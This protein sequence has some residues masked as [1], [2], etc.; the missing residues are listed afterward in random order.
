MWCGEKRKFWLQTRPKVWNMNTNLVWALMWVI[1][2]PAH[3]ISKPFSYSS[4]SYYSYFCKLQISVVLKLTIQTRLKIYFVWA[5]VKKAMSLAKTET[6]DIGASNELF[7][8]TFA[9]RLEFLSGNAYFSTFLTILKI[10]SRVNNVRNSNSDIM[11]KRWSARY[12]THSAQV[13]H[14]LFL[15]LFALLNKLYYWYI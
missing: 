1:E 5:P 3:L 14:F 11:K 15:F 13:S 10:I 12:W 7:R 2:C 6:H 8:I 9:V 4:Y